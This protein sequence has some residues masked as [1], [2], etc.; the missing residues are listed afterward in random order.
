MA[1]DLLVD[2]LVLFVLL[3]LCMLLPAY[4]WRDDQSAACLVT[5]TP[6]GSPR[7]RTREPN[8]SL[9]SSTN[10]TAMP[11]SK[12]PRHLLYPSLLLRP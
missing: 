12:P 6:D 4:C 10:R 1:L 3:W 5:P 2:E 9:A 11:V 8:R 7:K